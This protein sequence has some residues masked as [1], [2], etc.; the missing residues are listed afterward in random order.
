MA[1][2]KDQNWQY[3]PWLQKTCYTWSA[4]QNALNAGH[5]HLHATGAE[6]QLNST[7]V[8]FL[9]RPHPLFLSHTHLMSYGC[10]QYVFV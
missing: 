4:A 8:E 5:I 2:R 7:H 10:W 1:L 3:T 6:G 9:E